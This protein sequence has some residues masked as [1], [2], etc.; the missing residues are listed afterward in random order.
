MNFFYDIQTDINQTAYSS[1]SSNFEETDELQ[2]VGCDFFG[3]K[4]EN[5]QDYEHQSNG[6]HSRALPRTPRLE[7]VHKSSIS[8]WFTVNRIQELLTQI[9]LPYV[10][11]PTESWIPQSG[12]KLDDA[13]LRSEMQTQL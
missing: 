2:T 1:N 13:M 7:P 6:N 5:S 10:V 9:P 3:Y 4:L 12:T 11:A 8:T